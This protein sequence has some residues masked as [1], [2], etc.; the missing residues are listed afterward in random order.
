MDKKYVALCEYEDFRIFGNFIKGKNNNSLI[1]DIFI[2]DT[3]IKEIVFRIY[4]RRMYYDNKEYA[5]IQDLGIK[6]L[7]ALQF[8]KESDS[9]ESLQKT[10]EIKKVCDGVFYKS[11]SYPMITYYELEEYKTQQRQEKLI[12][13][14]NKRKH[15]KKIKEYIDEIEKYGYKV[16]TGLYSNLVLDTEKNIVDNEYISIEEILR[17]NKEIYKK[18]VKFEIEN[19]E[20]EKEIEGFK[21]VIEEIKETLDITKK[22]W[23]N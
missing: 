15:N 4:D 14:R 20:K 2:V 9:L 6:V 18:Y 5:N 17:N 7:K 3:K 11:K 10:F 22:D 1:E 13:E 8:I 23:Y 21:R 19:Y 12:Y 16:V